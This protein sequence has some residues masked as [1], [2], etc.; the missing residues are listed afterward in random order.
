MFGKD[1]NK[2]RKNIFVKIW[3]VMKRYGQALARFLGFIL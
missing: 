2:N 3:R 1:K